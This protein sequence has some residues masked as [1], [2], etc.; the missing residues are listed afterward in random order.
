[1]ISKIDIK[2]ITDNT[3]FAQEREKK[4]KR[5]GTYSTPA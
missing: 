1:M 3:I 2:D 4:I 5:K